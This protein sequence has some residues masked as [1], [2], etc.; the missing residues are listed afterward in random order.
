MSKSFVCLGKSV[1]LLRAIPK[2]VSGFIC[3]ISASAS[4]NTPAID[5]IE[6]DWE[7]N[8][9]EPAPQNNSPQVT[10]FIKPSL[11]EDTSYFQIQMN[12]AAKDSYSAGGFHVAA[13]SE[14]VYVDEA[15]SGTRQGLS[16]DR[17]TI[18]WTNVMAVIDHQLFFAIK[19]GH[20][21]DW[22]AFGG[23]EYL[24][25]MPAGT[26]EDLTEYHPNQSVADVDI[27]FGGNRVST[28][29]L[30]TVRAYYRDGTVVSFPINKFVPR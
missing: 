24:V 8:L 4:E 23:P 22:G 18:S 15:R 10:F 27:G 29:E 13:V 19:N 5:R 21:T 14:E 16:I 3:V 12:Y 25:K 30:K 26:I 2:L 9:I 11:Q 1:A 7:M 17:D 6:E 28:I 20:C